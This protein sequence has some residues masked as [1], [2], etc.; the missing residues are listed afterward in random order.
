MVTGEITYKP[1]NHRAGKAG[2]SART[3]GD[4]RLLFLLQAGHGCGQHPAFPAPSSSFRGRC[5]SNNSDIPCR[6]NEASCLLLSCSAKAGHP[7]R[8]SVRARTSLSLG[9]WIARSSRATTSASVAGGLCRHCE[10]QSDEAIQGL[11]G[12]L[13]LALDCFACARN[14]GYEMDRSV[15]AGRV[16]MLNSP[17]SPP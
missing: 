10:E 5:C 4:C 1:S 6:E 7:V 3:C 16:P 8:R 14:D 13:S 17:A 15:R 9:Y 2:C 12:S 11:A